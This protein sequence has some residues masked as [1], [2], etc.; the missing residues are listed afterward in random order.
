MS[1]HE[2][3]KGCLSWEE[4]SKTVAPVS[5]WVLPLPFPSSHH[6]NSRKQAKPFTVVILSGYRRLTR[7]R[8]SHCFS[9][10]DFFGEIANPSA[11]VWRIQVESVERSIVRGESC[12]VGLVFYHSDPTTFFMVK[13]SSK[14]ALDWRLQGRRRRKEKQRPESIS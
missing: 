5:V 2:E 13:K 4:K 6:H 14:V 12:L 10:L 8:K 1:C 3:W 9:P 7:R 11:K